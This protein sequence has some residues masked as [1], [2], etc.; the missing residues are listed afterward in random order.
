MHMVID[1]NIKLCINIQTVVSF[2]PYKGIISFYYYVC[3]A[4]GLVRVGTEYRIEN[5]EWNRSFRIT[6]IRICFRDSES[7]SIL[8]FVFYILY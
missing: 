3:N 6:K 4:Q 2:H 1:S 7:D 8:Y 5:V